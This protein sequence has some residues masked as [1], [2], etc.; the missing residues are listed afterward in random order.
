[1]LLSKNSHTMG[2]SK[3]KSPI[4]SLLDLV[5]HCSHSGNVSILSFTEKSLRNDPQAQYKITLPSWT[6][7]KEELGRSLLSFHYG[8][9]TTR[10]YHQKKASQENVWDLLGLDQHHDMK[11]GSWEPNLK[12]AAVAKRLSP[13]TTVS[14]TT[15]ASAGGLSIRRRGN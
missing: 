5:D 9:R 7:E 14:M 12:A 1:M 6:N 4:Q 15:Q 11:N 13:T 3:R 8:I 2:Q 10:W